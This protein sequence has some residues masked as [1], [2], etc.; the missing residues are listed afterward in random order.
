MFDVAPNAVNNKH[1]VTR[2][3]IPISGG[4][5]DCNAVLFECTETGGTFSG[6]SFDDLEAARTGEK[7]ITLLVHTGPD[8]V[9][10]SYFVFDYYGSGRG[11]FHY[12]FVNLTDRDMLVFGGRTGDATS[13]TWSHETAIFA[14]GDALDQRPLGLSVLERT[15]SK[16]RLAMSAYSAEDPSKSPREGRLT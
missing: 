14:P 4:S 1:A 13:Y 6:P 10:D 2:T 5:G 7:I 16:V 3:E 12:N 8:T 15:M 9:Q 11:S